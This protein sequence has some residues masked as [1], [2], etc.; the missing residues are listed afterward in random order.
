MPRHAENGIAPKPATAARMEDSYFEM[1]ETIGSLESM[2]EAQEA[3]R[4]RRRQRKL[5]ESYF[6]KFIHPQLPKFRQ[7]ATA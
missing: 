7:A 1:D 5:S 2:E 3:E 6:F 4:L